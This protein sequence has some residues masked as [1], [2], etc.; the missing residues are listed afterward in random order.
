[1]RP[2]ATY[3]SFTEEMGNEGIG[4]WK[5]APVRIDDL[6]DFL[7][8]PV[9]HLHARRVVQ[10]VLVVQVQA[11]DGARAIFFDGSVSHLVLQ[12]SLVLAEAKK[13]LLQL[14][15]VAGGDDGNLRAWS[16]DCEEFLLPVGPY[17]SGR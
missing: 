1:M 16:A 12:L 14:L 2:F 8:Q 11:A 17:M 9:G 15:V 5:L 10:V 6:H 4:R 3:W 7:R 13:G